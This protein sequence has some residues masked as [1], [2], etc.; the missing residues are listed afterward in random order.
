[1]LFSICC[2]FR[3]CMN[4]TK[5]ITY[6]HDEKN[7]SINIYESNCDMSLIDVY[8]TYPNEVIF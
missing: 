7:S 6:E 4:N 8:N 1:M 2:L 3:S 5:E